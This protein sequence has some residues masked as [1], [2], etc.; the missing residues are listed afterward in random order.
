MKIILI[1]SITFFSLNIHSQDKEGNPPII[2]GE[3]IFGGGGKINGNA[4]ILK[5]GEI[6]Y[7]YKNALF[8]IRYLEN[9]QLESDVLFLT[10][11]TPFP[12]LRENILIK[13]QVCCMVKDR[14]MEETSKYG[15]FYFIS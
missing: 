11:V 14:S 8:S 1:L 5:G 3:I 13:K 12:I 7:Q 15:D 2:Y 10:P 4:G 6:N 9:L